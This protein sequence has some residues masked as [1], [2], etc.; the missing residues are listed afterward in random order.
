MLRFKIRKKSI[1]FETKSPSFIP[2]GSVIGIVGDDDSVIARSPRENPTVT[3]VVLDVADDGSLGHRSEGKDVADDK[4]GLLPA[5]NELPG[6]HPLGG[7]EELLLVLEAEGVAE[8]DASE[9]RTTPRVVDD[10]SDDS[11]EVAV[12]LAEVEGTEASRA[13]PVVGVGLEHGTR[14][15]TLCSDDATH[16][17]RVWCVC[18]CGRKTSGGGE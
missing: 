14:S 8:G 13:L 1:K 9:R 5:V 12:A 7:D 11:L 4:V 6:V 3:D 10:L 2:R 18:E 17:R 16:F 15:L